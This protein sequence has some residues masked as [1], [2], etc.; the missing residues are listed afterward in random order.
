MLT[1]QAERRIQALLQ[2]LIEELVGDKHQQGPQPF[3]G[4]KFQYLAAS[5]VD[6]S[7]S[8][9][10]GKSFGLNRLRIGSSI[11]GG[12]SARMAEMASRMSCVA[13]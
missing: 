3:A 12:R 10:I 6:V 13:S 5:T 8:W 1:L 2:L 4:A 9:T 7:E 11:S